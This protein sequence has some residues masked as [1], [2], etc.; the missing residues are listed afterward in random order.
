MNAS[1]SALDSA[2][3][4]F[5]RGA[6]AI[7][8]I[9]MAI[10]VTSAAEITAGGQL[11]VRELMIAALGCNLAWGLIDGAIYLMHQQF[12]RYRNHRTMLEL[13]GSASTE[14]F[15]ARVVEALPPLI[16][17]V[18]SEDSFARL[19]KVV[20]AYDV[21]KPPLWSRQEFVIA[22][23]IA[24]ICFGS[25]FPL[26]V[27]FGVMQDPWLAL[28]VSHAVAA[29]MLFFLGWR[30]GRWSGVHPL[31]AGATFSLVGVALAIMCVALGG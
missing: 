28:R 7:F 15:R 30:V 11:D 5:E 9:L 2:L 22:G 6:E 12:E 1:P 24:L 3:S 16:G 31:A 25:T 21:R 17:P 18:F 26:V 4:P 8:G 14:D 29:G 19:R 27:P 10:S 23:L 20:D 13:R